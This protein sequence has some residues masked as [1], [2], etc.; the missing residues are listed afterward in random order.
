MT[1]SSDIDY[2][3]NLF[4]HPELSRIVGEP[5][6]ATLITLQA[7][8]RDNAQSVQSDLGGGANGHL[9]LV[10]TPEAYSS[11]V[12]NA[13]PYLRPTNPG[14][15]QIANDLTQYQIAQARDQHNEATRVFREIVSVE[16]ALIQQIVLAIEP[17]FLRALR[18]SGTN[19]LNRTIP[20]VLT[21]LFETYGDVT[22]HD[23]RELTSRVESLTFPNTEPVDTIFGEIDDL[24]AI[25]DIA[26]APISATQKINIA[27]IHFQKMLLYK[28]TLNRWDEKE[29]A[30]KTWPQFKIHFRDA[31]KALRRTG[32]LTIDESLNKDQIMNLVT[33]GV[34]NVL[35]ELPDPS[36]TSD[37]STTNHNTDTSGSAPSLL[38]TNSFTDS[39]NSTVSDLTIQIMQ[40]QIDIMQNMMSQ[41]QNMQTTVPLTS[42]TYRR[43]QRG[44]NRQP[45]GVPSNSNQSKYCWTHGL[46]NHFGR[47]CRTKA[48]G[49][50]DEATRHR[51][52]GG[53]L[54]NIPANE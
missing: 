35:Q 19:K 50:R 6:T 15:L 3:N 12:P 17:K 1:N 33:E 24:A 31:H 37:A 48:D 25:A 10:C 14:R 8:V 27:Y 16:R 23:L 53:S 28:S 30:M 11:L 4:E 44:P 21:H 52:M 7:E 5:T 9:G 47:D 29:L 49:H 32:A 40:R 46:C 43:T 45:T 34:M 18:T 36:I 38:S 41:M 42:S 2:K 39:T 51:R 22:P 26:G 13:T 20:Q 54:R